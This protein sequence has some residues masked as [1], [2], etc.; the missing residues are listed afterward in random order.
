MHAI[1]AER[2]QVTIPKR[3]RDRLG[4]TPHT[5][6]DFIEDEG[7][8]IVTKVLEGDAVTRVQGCLR[9]GRKTDLVIR[10]LRGDA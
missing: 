4:L 1:I 9:L 3:I 10:E 6:V 7:R 8:V 2:G 5:V